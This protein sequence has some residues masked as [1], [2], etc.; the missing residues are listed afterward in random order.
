MRQV[1]MYG[2]GQHNRIPDTYQE[3]DSIV[4]F[5]VRV[6][7][8]AARCG[9]QGVAGWPLLASWWRGLQLKSAG[10]LDRMVAFEVPSH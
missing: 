2:P 4:P 3:K 8:P 1:V 9:R 10:W 7:Q 6:S 5:P